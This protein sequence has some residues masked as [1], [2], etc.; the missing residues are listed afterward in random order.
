MRRT[1]ALQGVR[2]MKFMDILSRYDAGDFSHLEAA[3]PF[4]SA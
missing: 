4:A 1:E 3:A 2:M